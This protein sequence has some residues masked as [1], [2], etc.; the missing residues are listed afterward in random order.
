MKKLLLALSCTLLSAQSLYAQISLS[1]SSFTGTFAGT[2]DTLLNSSSSS[3]YP[4]LTP[5][6]SATW[7]MTT[8][9]ATSPVAYG[10]NVSP[11]TTAFASAQFADSELNSL[12]TY[13][14]IANYER[15]FTSGGYMEYGE[16]INRQAIHLTG[17]SPIG[18]DDSIIFNAQNI[19]YS[20]P[21]TLLSFPATYNTHWSC[22]FN[23]SITF[24]LDIA[25]LSY[26]N[27]PGTVKTWT[28]ETDTVMGW[29]QMR[30]KE[31]S[32]TAG[33]YMHVLQVRKRNVTIDSF[34]VNGGA[35]TTVLL[36][37]LGLTQGQRTGTYYVDFYRP[38][39]A[40]PLATVTYTDSTFSTPKSATTL[41]ENFN[42]D[43]TAGVTTL[44]NGRTINI[45]PNP[46]TGHTIMIDMPGSQ[47]GNWAYELFNIAGGQVASGALPIS[48][49]QS[50][51]QI[52]L[53][54]SL[55][56]GI[57]YL[58]LKNNGEDIATRA[59]EIVK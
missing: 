42:T 59:L 7:D 29:G 47:N 49:N 14:Y 27:T 28:T 17:G 13:Q 18:P 9:V 2:T 30:V 31:T 52:D 12:S 37:A 48:S 55:T 1:S 25:V 51:A 45:Y 39:E 3:T 19:V 58:R 33:G 57:Y 23:D 5:A 15:A 38:G 44:G 56:P 34:Y 50:Q 54:G 24:A 20:S 21:W 35:A 41:A 53:P 46:A 36:G 11:Y 4:V 6:A 10:Y 16:H 40:R 22:S 43:L 8:A 32:G 26:V